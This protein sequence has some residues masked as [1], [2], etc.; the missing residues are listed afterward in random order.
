MESFKELPAK[1]LRMIATF[2]YTDR[3]GN[4]YEW[5]PGDLIILGPKNRTWVLLKGGLSVRGAQ[6]KGKHVLVPH[7]NFVVE[8]YTL[9]IPTIAVQSSTSK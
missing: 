4:E 2:S 9:Q 6:G 5:R 8:D 7:H 1:A 3:F